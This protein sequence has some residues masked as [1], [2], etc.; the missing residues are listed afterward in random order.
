MWLRVLTILRESQVP[1]K[2]A[3]AIPVPDW[4]A[5][6][7]ADPSFQRVDHF[8]GRNP[9]TGK[10]LRLPF[11]NSAIWLGHP[12][13][14]P[15]PFVFREGTIEIKWADEHVVSKAEAVAQLLGGIV[16][17]RDQD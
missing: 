17:G 4:L 15:V 1:G 3:A 5:V 14:V 6:V 11:P 7:A 16:E 2:G 13:F 10:E 9:A 8:P 12:R